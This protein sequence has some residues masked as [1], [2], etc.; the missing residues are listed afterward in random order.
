MSKSPR[1]NIPSPPGLPIVGNLLDIQDEVPIRGLENIADTYG[2]MFKLNIMGRERLFAA[3]VALLDELCDESRFWKAP[4]DGL[5]PL[6]QGGGGG[7]KGLFTAES[8]E[9]MDWQLAHRIL[10]PAFGPL[11]IQDMF[12]EMH[13]IASQLV[14]KWARLGPSYSILVTSD[15]TRLTLDTIALCAMDY[16]FNSF[17]QDELHPFVQAMN[18]SLAFSSDRTKLGSIVKRLLPWDKSIQKLAADRQYMTSVSKELVELRRNNP[19]NKRD[20]LNAMVLGK[21]P[22][23]SEKMSDGLIASNMTTFLIAGHETTSGLLSFAFLFLLQHPDAYFKAQQ[24]VDRVLGRGKIEVRHLQELKYI[25]AVFRETLRLCPTAPAFTRSIRKDNPNDVEEL[26]GGKYAIN[27]DDKVLCL[28][29]K[30]QRDPEVYGEDANDFKPERMLGDA[31]NKLPKSAWKPFGTGLRSCIGR[32]F[33]WQEAQLAMAMILQNFN[34]RL[35]DPGYQ[36]RIKQTL[37]IK[38]EGLY[39]RATL[40]DGI[41]AA[42]LQTALASSPDAVRSAIED[43]ISRADSG[44]EDAKPM[45]IL[46]GSNTGESLPL[47]SHGTC[48]A[49]AQKLSLEG[50]RH[51]FDARVMELNDAVDAIPRD[52]QP[53]VLITAS[54]EGQPTDNAAQFVKWLEVMPP[55]ESRFE[56]VNFA[57]FGCGHRDWTGTFHRIPKLVDELFKKHGATQTVRAG[58]ADAAAGDIFSQFED[59]TD[60][61]FW[62]SVSPSSGAAQE[63]PELE[64]DV[65]TRER[66]TYL[67]QDVRKG[68]VK[69]SWCLTAD[70]EPEKRHL[71]IKLPDNMTYEAGDY[72]AILPL[73]PQQTVTRVMKHFKIS[74]LA[75]T[76]IKPGAATFLP[77]GVPLSIVEL[78]KGFVELSLPATKR[79][80][81]A[82][83]ACTSD[84]TE[85]EEL[86]AL[87]SES[88][89]RELD[90]SH[91]SLLDLLERYT[92]IGLGFNTFI[93]MLQPLKPRLY[94]I[95]SSPLVDATSCTVTYGVIDEDAKSG[96]GRYVGVTGSYLSGL[97][98]GDEI[99]VSVRATNRYFHL[100][101]EIS[102]TPILMFGA[103]TGI[104]PFRGFIQERAQQIAAGRSLAPAIMYMGCRSS[105]SDRLYSDEMDKWVKHGVVDIRYAFSQES[106]AS[107][108]CKYIQ[109]R[110]W[111][112]REDVIRLWRDGA[113]VF[114]CGGPAVCEGLGDVSRKLLLES[115]KSRGQE[116]SEKEA[117]LWFRERRNVRYVVDVFA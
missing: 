17:Y 54:Y 93:A 40:R 82:C 18:T 97:M 56:G 25:D 38:P 13:D 32:A 27:R 66:S 89:F 99:L 1:D 58:F 21:D 14:L 69:S 72:L 43:T 112:E 31:F 24:E 96:N 35:D 46:Y 85:K 26:L 59:W 63:A 65:A 20:L 95:S 36:M 30:C 52:G 2:G 90:E 83:I 37:T 22:N 75:T 50:R 61:S 100:P 84:T 80:I 94:S 86:R 76:T 51:G 115:M 78:L 116:M 45:T 47:G 114:V 110:M 34:I 23:T 88:A 117:E 39:M 107:E 55:G 102:Q 64:M 74:A 103:G 12:D 79:D 6:N 101:A 106:H 111:K 41:S 10:M 60:R 48:T 104:A 29:S 44:M 57:V 16:R 71:E 67:R 8:E 109:D 42:T 7:S 113:K 73:N 105:S 62:P 77:T 108:G 91:V 11:A 81:Q 15:F 87:Q 5:N 70:G 33:A 4:G 98:T 49:L 9:T 3:N 68:I 53:V 28:L 92:S 19:T